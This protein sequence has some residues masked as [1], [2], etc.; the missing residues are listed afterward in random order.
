VNRPRT[1]WQRWEITA[2]GALFTT[3]ASFKL[4]DT[5]G[6]LD[7]LARFRAFPAASLRLIA[8]AW[9][10]CELTAGATLL[11]TGL[12]SRPSHRAPLTGSI[13]ASLSWLAYAALLYSAHVRSLPITNCTFFG[14]HLAQP[15]S[16]LAL[17]Q[18]ALL[19]AVTTFLLSK[20]AR[21]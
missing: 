15:L 13:L 6:Y 5:H 14:A 12:T 1:R 20:F 9:I 8:A 21:R 4:A 10:A 19:L 16:L 2:L 3:Q 18:S 7:A 17:A 11:Y